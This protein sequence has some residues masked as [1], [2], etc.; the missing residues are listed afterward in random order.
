MI[1]SNHEIHIGSSKET[2]RHKP[3]LCLFYACLLVK[4]SAEPE[5]LPKVQSV[6]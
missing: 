2:R 5:Y 3:D 6:L 4:T 1:A